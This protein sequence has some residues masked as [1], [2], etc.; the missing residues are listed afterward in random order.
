[1]DALPAE[2]YSAASV[3]AMDRHAIEAAGIP[4][5]DLMQRAGGAA[6][7]CAAPP[8][9]A[10]IQASPCSAA[11]ATTRATVMCWRASRAPRGSTCASSR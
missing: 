11:P 6:F 8:L 1:M 7:E 2:V 5:Y 10:S 9:A 3:R 4:G